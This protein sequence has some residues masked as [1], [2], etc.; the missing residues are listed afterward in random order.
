MMELRLATA[1]FIRQCRGAR[2]CPETTDDSMEMLDT[3]TIAPKA[4]RCNIMIE[5]K[6]LMED[7]V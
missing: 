1:V 4:H 2:L 3:F 6:P 7:N 5:K